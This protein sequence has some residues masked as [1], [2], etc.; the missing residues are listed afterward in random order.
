MTRTS[1]VHRWPLILIA[2]PA[3]VAIWSGWVGLGGMCGFGLV[4]PLPGIVAWHLDTAITLPVGVEAYG[5]YALGVWM[6]PSAIPDAARRFARRSAIGALVLGM[7]GQVIYHLLAAAHAHRAPWPVVVLVS[8]LPVV[9]LG[10]GA[11]LTHLLRVPVAAPEADEAAPGTAPEAVSAP[12]LEDEAEHIPAGLETAAVTADQSVQPS[13]VTALEVPAE[14][15]TVAAAATAPSMVPADA[16]AAAR[17]A[18]EASVRAANP[19][20]ARQLQAR[21]GLSRTQATKVRKEFLAQPG[22]D[23]SSDDTSR[24]VLAAVKDAAESAPEGGPDEFGFADLKA[25]LERP[26]DHT[27]RE[28]VSVNGSGP[29]A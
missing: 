11:G 4:Q 8:C 7:T 6:R 1:T 3:A 5:A 19:I 13:A 15:A 12:A 10:F 16:V 28:V 2:A 26:I 23:G 24:P 14:A 18:M 9:V 25:L 20:S 22:D 27:P 21:F 29:D 17:M